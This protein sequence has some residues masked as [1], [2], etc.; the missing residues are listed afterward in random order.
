VT[1]APAK[2]ASAGTVAPIEAQAAS[3][4]SQCEGGIVQG[5]GYALYEQRHVDPLT[6]QVLTANLEDYRLPGIGDTPEITIHFHTEG[7][8]HVN[9]GGVGLGEISTIGVAASIGNA[10]YNATGWRPYDLP[11]RPDRVLAGM[12]SP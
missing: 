6:G 1:V 10:V 12:E 8:E 3:S 7:W 11:I 2:R 5:I 4:V 9:G